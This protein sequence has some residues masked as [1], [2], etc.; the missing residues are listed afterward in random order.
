MACASFHGVS[1]NANRTLNV[2]PAWV[3]PRLARTALGRTAD[4]PKRRVGVPRRGG[5]TPYANGKEKVWTIFFLAKRMS[6]QSKSSVDKG[7]V[8]KGYF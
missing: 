1:N 6:K 7:F 3:T 2:L 4:A 5:H 8:D